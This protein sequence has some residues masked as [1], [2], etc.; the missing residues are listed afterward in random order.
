MG[1]SLLFGTLVST[2]LTLIVVPLGINIAGNYLLPHEMRR[3]ADDECEP[4]APPAQ[5]VPAEPAASP[6]GTYEG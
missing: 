1:L 3:Q 5:P 4:E 2:L 6:Y